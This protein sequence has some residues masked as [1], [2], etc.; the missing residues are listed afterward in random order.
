M[1]NPQE[2]GK[3][4]EAV[5][6]AMFETYGVLVRNA[7]ALRGAD[8]E[9]VVEQID[10]VIELDGHLYFTELKWWAAPLGKA[11]IAEHLIRVFSR[12]E[13]RAAI[14]STS[15]FSDAAI[16]TCRDALPN[17]VVV[18][19]TLEELV[20]LLE[21]EEDLKK[22]MRRKIHAAIIDKNPFYRPIFVGEA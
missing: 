3:A 17:K 4:L 22:F 15:G 13:S 11:E 5:L 20:H 8:G 7:F 6:N 12:A 21:L 2:R 14:I 19:C 16:A 9:G 18:L 10:G 1:T